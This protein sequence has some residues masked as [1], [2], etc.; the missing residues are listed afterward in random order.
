MGRE[1]QRAELRFQLRAARKYP[2]RNAYW[3]QLLQK[4]AARAR[5]LW[6]PAGLQENVFRCSIFFRNW[7]HQ[8]WT[9]RNHDIRSEL[10]QQILPWPSRLGQS[11]RRPVTR[12]PSWRQIWQPFHSIEIS[13]RY[14]KVRFP[15][16]LYRNFTGC[17]LPDPECC[18]FIQKN[19]VFC[20]CLTG[21]NSFKIK[22]V[23]AIERLT[24]LMTLVSSFPLHWIIKSSYSQLVLCGAFSPSRQ[25]WLWFYPRFCQSWHPR[26]VWQG[27]R[28]RAMA[29]SC[30]I[31]IGQRM[32]IITMMLRQ[33]N[34][35]PVSP[36]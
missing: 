19:R 27:R 10:V 32:G 12:A 22:G 3:K 25:F 2:Q 24:T 14:S 33:P 23:T 5:P 11:C 15:F 16:M 6:Q 36:W 18:I 13:W 28:C 34:R 7:V 35:I 26:A 30:R 21:W 9:A 29:E 20:N 8:A 4:Q 17:I 31:A 1:G